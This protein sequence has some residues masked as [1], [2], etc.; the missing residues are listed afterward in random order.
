[1][2]APWFL[3]LFV[4]LFFVSPPVLPQEHDHSHHAAE[5]LGEVHFPV[6]CKPEVQK[7]FDRAV[8]LLHSFW[9]GEAEKAF[10]AISKTDPGCGMAYWGMAM[11]NFHPL[12]A[13]PT[14]AEMER[15]K[16]AAAKAVAL[17][18]KTDREKAFIA[19]I[20]AFYRESDTQ[21]HRTRTLAYEKA[22]EQMYGSYPEDLEVAAFYGLSLLGTALP[23]DK[24]YANQKKAAGILN[25]LVERA[26]KHPGVAH[27]IIH[28]FDYPAL[29]ELG[30]PA[31]RAYAKIAPASPHAQHMPSHIFTRLGLWQESI[32][33][34]IASAKT[35]REHAEAAQPGSGSYDQLHALDYLTYAYLQLGQDEKARSA[36]EEA[37]SIKKLDLENFAAAYAFASI[38]A[39]F[40]MERHKWDEAAA[41]TLKPEWVQWSKFPYAEAN[42][43]FARAV[44]AA[45]SG[46]P[47]AAAQAEQRLTEITGALTEKNDK[48]W[49]DQVSILK[50][51][52]D[53]WISYAKGDAKEALRQM[54]SA[55]SLEDATEKHPVSPGYIVPA[56]EA[57]GE[58][59]LEMKQP[60]EALAEFEKSLATAPNRLNSFAGAVVAA[61]RSG[62][63]ASA[64]K[65]LSKLTTLTAQAD[66]ERAVVL[67]AKK[68]SEK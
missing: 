35:A 44:G 1:M 61:K 52:A 67:Q 40:A 2:K 30:L 4:F 51:M 19:A 6:S 24:T 57:L 45:R 14:P 15:G 64:G 59:L 49:A 5:E 39:R 3:F 46:K 68:I 56:H 9:Y 65:Y 55:A 53:A 48:Y 34:N 20:D 63:E 29:A 8:A 17:S 58:L 41:L 10:D 13:P 54:Q 28:S 33:S 42:L 50:Q 25:K 22:M 7:D 62:N 43:H 27:Y 32:S 38:P 21:D 16:A 23:S 11:S 60:A 26:P 36:M 37:L 66:S 47:D 12:W 31:A 18:A